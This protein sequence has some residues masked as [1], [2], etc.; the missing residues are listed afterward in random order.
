MKMAAKQI[1]YGRA[2]NRLLDRRAADYSC[3]YRFCDSRREDTVDAKLL[4]TPRSLKYNDTVMS[5]VTQFRST[6]ISATNAVNNIM[7]DC[8][9]GSF[10]FLDQ[11]FAQTF[12]ES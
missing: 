1:G 11:S 5:R 6:S 4:S 7:S 8:D 9:Y 10:H 2:R 3:F 12:V